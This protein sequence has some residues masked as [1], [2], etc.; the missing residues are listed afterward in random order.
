MTGSAYRTL[1]ILS[2]DIVIGVV[3]LLRFFC[4]QF[5]VEAG[6]QVYALLAI[7]VWVI[8]TL[9]HLNDAR[10]V[11]SQRE[12]YRFHSEHQKFLLIAI[13]FLVF[14]AVSLLF[15]IPLII[16]IGGVILAGLSGIYLMIQHRLSFFFSKELYVSLVYTLGI[17][18]VPS[19]LA[20]QFRWDF[21]ILLFL[22][23]FSNLVIFS[24]YERF[25]D[26]QDGF[27]SIATRLTERSVEKIV[28][29]SIVLGLSL[30]ILAFDKVYLF[31]TLSFVVYTL[32]FLRRFFFQQNHWY[33][34]LGDAVFLL[35]ILFEWL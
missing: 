33:R 17:M 15:F 26:I 18:M 4:A 9:D 7:T 16:V 19:L 29:L 24:W 13:L 20:Q 21:T 8:Y 34:T 12:R 3:I 14:F 35:P 30:S 27:E 11:D 32:L 31:F 5:G 1:Q 10:K 25:D 28:L 22:L 2:I 23:S 6:W